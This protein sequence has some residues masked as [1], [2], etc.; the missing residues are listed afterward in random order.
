[1]SKKQ[2]VKLQPKVAV[3]PAKAATTAIGMLNAI[4]NFLGKRMNGIFWF[5]FALG[6]LFTILQFDVKLSTGHD[7]AL[8]IEAAYDFIHQFPHYYYTANAPLYPLFLT[9]PV[10][11]FGINLIALKIISMIFM[12]AFLFV[13]YKTFLGKIP[14]LI[15]ISV[16][17]IVAVNPDFIYFA[18]MTYTE[19]FFLFLQAIF[20]YYFI[21]HQ[22]YILAEGDNI[23]QSWKQWLMIGFLMF[24]LVFAKSAAYGAL[25]AL[26]LYFIINKKYK[27]AAYSIA[28]FMMFKFAFDII[29]KIVWGDA[30]NNVSGQ[31]RILL[32]KNAYNAAEGQEDLS[33]FIVRFFNNLDLY[34]SKRMFQILGF[35]DDKSTETRTLLSLIVVILFLFGLYKAFKN[36][37]KYLLFVGLYV[38]AVCGL[39]FLMLQ[40]TWDQPRII[41]IHIPFI[42]IIIIYG[43]Y[44]AIGNREKPSFPLELITLFFI[45]IISFAGVGKSLTKTAK[46]YR[47]FQ[48]NIKGDIFYGYSPDWAN[49]L[50]MSEWSAKNL[51]DSAMVACR[52]A[53][54]SFV[55]GK[56]R[57]FFGIYTVRTS[58][59]D[60]ILMNFKENKVTHIIMASLRRNPNVNTGE[61]IN[62]IQRL[63]QPINEKYPQKLKLIKQIGE[64]E[65]AYLFEI[66]YDAK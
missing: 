61:V 62:T 33:G 16:F 10:G 55:Y 7:D 19:A 49:Y 11:I 40:V 21:K 59:A 29:K 18:C 44:S 34:L 60:S 47:I 3:K 50:Q 8:Y 28:S 14:N 53:P 48:K 63:L 13:F 2:I 37:Q 30:A 64:T 65:P 58:N 66:K 23:K 27:S 9:I 5:I 32:Q 51:P 43:I 1:M 41:L 42:L 17:F 38:A 4:D 26:A 22:D 6:T 12:L 25:P 52:K 31:L 35:V 20:F 39:S 15:I 36:G 46:N 54:M 24:L 57:K 56:G 45:L